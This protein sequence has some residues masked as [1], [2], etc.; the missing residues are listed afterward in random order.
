[1]RAGRGA[2]RAL[3]SLVLVAA[4]GC[5]AKQAGGLHARLILQPHDTLQFTADARA[6]RCGGGRGFVLEGAAGGSGLLL[7]VRSGDSAVG[8][9]Y[10]VLTRGDSIASRG[11]VGGVR[12]MIKETD[13]GITL[14]SG[15]VSVSSVEG[16]IDAQARGSG[17]DPN[18]GQRVALDASFHAVPIAADTAS[19]HVQL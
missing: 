16:R 13:H 14:D 15:V 11:V 5:R 6:R 1:M 2:L 18:A 12:F 3:L 4:C 17:I 7:W 8:G 9:E 10:P 19:C